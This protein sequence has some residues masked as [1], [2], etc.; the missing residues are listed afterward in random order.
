M[1]TLIH[2]STMTK[3]LHI[4]CLSL[5]VQTPWMHAAEADLKTAASWQV[6]TPIVTYWCGPSL[7]DAVAQ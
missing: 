4:L 5:F 3:L 6:G 2:H 1:K 7:T